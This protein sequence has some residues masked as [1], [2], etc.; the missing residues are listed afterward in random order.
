MFV[1]AGVTGKTGKVAAES[2]LRRGERV[3]VLVRSARGAAVWRAKGAE[4]A[5]L[6]LDDAT[7][8]SAALRGARGFYALVPEDPLA[9]DFS[10]QR[11]AIVSAL[12]AAVGASRVPHV[13]LLSALAV[14]AA[15][16]AGPAAEL[17]FAELL[18]R[19]TAT[20]LSVLRASYFQENVLSA[21]TPARRDG[22][23]P[24]FFGSPDFTVTTNATRDVGELAAALLLDPPARSR[25]VDVVGP[26]YSIGQLAAL[27]GNAL[28]TVLHVVDVPAAQ[29]VQALCSAGMSASYAHAL[30]ELFAAYRA[31]H[32]TPRADHAWHV[33]TRLEQLLPTLLAVGAAAAQQAH[34]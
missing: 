15:E 6:S 34:G 23:F 12:A 20:N 1:V 19:T 5:L 9:A 33:N 31:G 28:G 27:L 24:N 30:R 25:T 21:Y 13:V 4:A 3:R 32:V 22:V 10:A 29:H 14:N 11:R 8:L 7:A 26:S 18:L 16:P 2:L 17:R